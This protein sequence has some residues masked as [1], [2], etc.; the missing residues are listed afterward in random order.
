M[1]AAMNGG[2]RLTINAQLPA[3]EPLE[4]S[5]R[6]DAVDDN[7][8]RAILDQEI[9]TGTKANPE[10]VVAH[11]YVFIPLKTKGARRRQE[12]RKKDG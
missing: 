7:G 11:L 9:V 5:G 4:V 3:G 8:A 2:C 1:L 12:K 10:A 6:L